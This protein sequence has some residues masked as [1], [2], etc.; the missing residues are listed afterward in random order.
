MPRSP[1][2]V[3]HDFTELVCRSCVNYEGADRIE[4]GSGREWRDLTTLVI[5]GD[6]Q[7]CEEDARRVRG[8]EWRQEREQRPVPRAQDGEQCRQQPAGR[9]PTVRV[10]RA[11]SP[12]H[13]SHVLHTSGRSGVHGSVRTARGLLQTGPRWSSSSLDAWKFPAA[14]TSYARSQDGRNKTKLAHHKTFVC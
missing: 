5:S 4:V 8:G 14:S 3:I 7:Q 11:E 13:R 9:E 2:A 10:P 1:W 12:H 6:P